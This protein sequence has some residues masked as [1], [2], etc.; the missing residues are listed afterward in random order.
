M[1]WYYI[2]HGRITLNSLS[3]TGFH[4]VIGLI[5]TDLILTPAICYIWPSI[6]QNVLFE[7]IILV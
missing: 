6:I 2:S 1:S 7:H 4:Q 5:L 3:L